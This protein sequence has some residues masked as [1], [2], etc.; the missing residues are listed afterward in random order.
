MSV[1]SS[2]RSPN[3]IQPKEGWIQSGFDK[4][5]STTSDDEEDYPETHN[6]V[7]ASTN[8]SKQYSCK[9]RDSKSSKGWGNF[10][11]NDLV[12]AKDVDNNW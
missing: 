7:W 9:K 4:M 3:F 2:D 10:M 5:V 12:D 8:S 6:D 11:V 1:L